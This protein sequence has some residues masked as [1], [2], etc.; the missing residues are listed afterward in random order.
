MRRQVKFYSSKNGWIFTSISWPTLRTPL[1]REPPATPPFKLSTSLPGLFTSNDLITISLRSSIV[2]HYL[3]IT[4]LHHVATPIW[5][6]LCMKNLLQSSKYW[7]NFGPKNI[8]TISYHWIL[9]LLF[10]IISPWFRSKISQGDGYFLDHIFWD[11][12]NVVFKL[13][14]YGNDWCVLCHGSFD[15]VYNISVLFNCLRK[16]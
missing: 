15:K 12:F 5:K 2:N 14:R 10:A 3:L 11:N 9:V 16:Y 4:C 7:S 13:S 6:A 1:S 8:N